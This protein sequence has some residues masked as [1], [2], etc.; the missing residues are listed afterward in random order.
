MSR[1][2]QPHIVTDDSALGGTIINGSLYKQSDQYLE[3]VFG[4]TGDRTKY[5]ES[6]WIKRGGNDFKTRSVFGITCLS[7]PSYGYEYIS[8]DTNDRL[9][10]MQLLMVL[11]L[12]GY[13][14]KENSE[15]LVGFM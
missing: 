12:D 8:F 6:I 10:G 7:D 13:K 5:T 3:K 2:F 15:E 14:Q 9:I 11:G 4:S 1:T